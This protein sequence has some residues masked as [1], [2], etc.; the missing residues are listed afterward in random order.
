MKLLSFGSNGNFQLGL[1]HSDDTDC[2]QRVLF[3]DDTVSLN[4]LLSVACGGNHTVLIT[5]DHSAYFS[6]DNSCNQCGILLKDGHVLPRFRKL[7]DV[8]EPGS[9]EPVK[10]K[11][12]AAGWEY[13]ILISTDNKIYSAGFGPKGELGQGSNVQSSDCFKRLNWFPIQNT[14]VVEV[15]ASLSHVVLRLDNGELW[16]WGVARKGQV[17][18]PAISSI[19]EPRQ[20]LVNGKPTSLVR[21]VDCGRMFTVFVDTDNKLQILGDDRHVKYNRTEIPLDLTLYQQMKCTW[22]SVHILDNSGKVLSWGNNS[23]GQ[24]APEVIR[25]NVSGYNSIPDIQLCEIST[26]TEHVL[27]LSLDRQVVYAWGWG[28]HGNCGRIDDSKRV[29]NDSVNYPNIVYEATEAQKVIAIF[30]GYASSWILIEDEL[31]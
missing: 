24:L 5:N 12:A 10:W 21:A 1:N 25:L 22:S 23:H 4:G 6:G 29:D 26:G 2:P 28:E 3:E 15:V 18:E 9:A 13:S 20:V 8:F 31:P 14:S 11:L 7:V 27:G 30:G 19:W 17:G 16:G